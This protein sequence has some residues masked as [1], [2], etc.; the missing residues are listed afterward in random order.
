MLVQ[1]KSVSQLQSKSGSVIVVIIS[2]AP[3]HYND[4]F[5]GGKL[6]LSNFIYYGVYA[7][8]QGK[9]DFQEDILAPKANYYYILLM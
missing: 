2:N 7:E 4:I 5:Y 8:D 1:G 3:W 6:V 9:G